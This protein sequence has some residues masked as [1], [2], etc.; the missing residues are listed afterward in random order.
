MSP[1]ILVTGGAGY[2]GGSVIATILS[3]ANGPL[4]G[5]SIFATVRSEKQLESLAKIGVKA[6]VTELQD[7]KAVTDVVVDNEIDIIISTAPSFIPVITANLIEALG[8]RREI[9]GIEP[10]YIHSSVTTLFSEDA[11][12]PY[13]EVRDSDPGLYEKEKEIMGDHPVRITSVLLFEEAEKHGVKAFNVVVPQVYGRGTGEGRKLSVNIPAYIRTAIKTKTVWKFD[14]DGSPPAAHIS[15]VVELY[16]L[17]AE[18]ALQKESIPSGKEGYYFAMVHR[19]PWWATMEKIAQSLYARGL[20]TEPKAETWPSY[21]K[22]A[23]NLGWP[24]LYIRAMGTSSGELIPVNGGKI[25]WQ[26][27]WDEKRYLESLD[28][29]VQ[30]VLDLDTGHADLFEVLLTSDKSSGST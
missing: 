4:K 5:A 27:K 26:P 15:D 18:K 20:V 8:K 13:G 6:F 2:I 19:S 16:A 17:I 24:S 11:G 25:G 23:E 9:A 12:W 3:R 10:Y 28:D 14:K 30:A 22:A 1:N 7:K 29:E 21:E